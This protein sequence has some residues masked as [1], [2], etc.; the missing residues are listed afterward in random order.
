MDRPHVTI[1]YERT[2]PHPVDQAYAWL[3]DYQDDDPQRAGDII[4]R[5][6]VVRRGAREVEL[7]GELDVMGTKARGR[8]LVRLFP[9]E[10]RWVATIGKGAW[11]FHYRVEPEGPGATRLKVDYHMGSRRWTRR[12]M[13][14]LATP[15]IRRRLDRMWDGFADAMRRELG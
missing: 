7:D 4:V 15:L 14:R 6:D 8:A 12:A 13:I 2:F 5:R 11:E 9:E 1:R 3:T 10:R